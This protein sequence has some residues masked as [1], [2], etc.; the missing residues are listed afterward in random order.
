MSD[1]QMRHGAHVFDGQESKLTV[2][3][4]PIGGVGAAVSMSRITAKTSLVPASAAA[5]VMLRGATIG[6]IE[7]TCA[8]I[9]ALRNAS[10]TIVAFC[11]AQIRDASRTSTSARTRNRPS[12][13][14]CRSGCGT[15]K[16]RYWPLLARTSTTVPSTGART[17]H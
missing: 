12:W 16:L 6:L 5:V 8:R 17:V 14:R 13:I 15:A 9:L 11:A 2:T 4:D 7:V 3:A 1:R 10:A